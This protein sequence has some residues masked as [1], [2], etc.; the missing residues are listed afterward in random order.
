MKLCV[1]S[2]VRLIVVVYGLAA[3]PGASSLGDA[4]EPIVYT[5][6]MPA[7]EKHTVEIEAVVP[8]G[9]RP[10]ID[11]MMAVWSPGYYRVQDYAKQIDKLTAHSSDGISLDVEQPDKNH[12]K[13][14]TNGAPR[15][16]LSYQ[17]TCRQV[18]VTTNYVDSELGVF[19]GAAT[20]LTLVEREARPHEIRLELPRDWKRSVTALEAAPDGLSDHYRAADYDTLVDSPIVAGNPTIHEFTVDGSK[21]YLVDIGAFGT[22]DGAKAAAALEKIVTETRRFWGFLPFKTYYFLNV[23]RRGAGGLEHKHSTLLTAGSASPAGFRWYSFASHEYFHAFNVKRL[24][25]VELGPF[26]YEHPPRT[27]SLWISE[28][29]TSYFGELIVVRAGLGTLDDYLAAMSSSINQLQSSP[30]RLV[31]SLEQSSL[32]VWGSGVSGVGRD[33]TKSISY[34]VKGPVVGLLL[35]ARIRNA[36]ADRKSLDD[37]MRLAYQRYAGERGFTPDEFRIVAEEVAGT[38]LKD[39]FKKAVNSAVELDYTE[40]LDWFGLRFAPSDAS[41]KEDKPAPKKQG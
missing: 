2:W 33:R 34:Y 15:V 20:F 8:T 41:I 3:L 9:K 24:R 31:Q 19:N 12:W 11:M 16:V 35:D 23:F 21:H 14:A 32:D 28:G 18:S 25:P 26:D 40:T 13:I 22:W 6:R 1:P 36:T 38:E 10:A 5:I 4:P 7:P 17:L 30:G 27:A 39:W 37:V 29:L